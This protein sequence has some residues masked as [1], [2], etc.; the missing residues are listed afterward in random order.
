MINILDSQ[1]NPRLSAP[2]GFGKYIAGHMAV[3]RYN[4][5]HGWDT[6]EIIPYQSFQLDPCALVL[7]YGQSIYEGMKAFARKDGS[8]GLF[9]PE[10]NA[11]RFRTSAARMAMAQMPCT[12]FLDAISQ[13]V[14]KEKHLIPQSE[15][16]SLYLRPV[17]IGDE[18]A[19]GVRR[20]ASYL[21]FTIATPVDDLYQ[22]GNPGMRLT[23]TEDFSRSSQ[24]GGG[25]A[26]TAGNYA[27]TI[28]ALDAARAAGFDN[29]L[30]LDPVHQDWIEEAGITNFFVLTRAGTLL[31]PP[32]NGRILA[33][34]TRDA[35]L[36]QARL[37]KLDIEEQ[38]ISISALVKAIEKDDIA[39]VFMTGTATH[40]A[41][42]ASLSWRGTEYVLPQEP[43]RQTLAGRLSQY[44][45]D[46]QRGMCEDQAGWMTVL[47]T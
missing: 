46:V 3:C 18:A 47:P 15:T 34:V 31:T 4:A 23:V 8:I 36:Q 2:L 16:G 13:L 5:E 26:K 9:R 44:I 33:G 22:P 20:S 17:L 27:R 30:W 6:P 10:K 7:H 28:L 14:L 39:E 35:V 37:W 38:E 43:F 29:V 19:F 21:F 24:R 12:L 1:Q 42:V 25:D 40:I 11:E 41:P 45:R 32:L